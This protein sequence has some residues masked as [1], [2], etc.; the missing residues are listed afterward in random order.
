MPCRGDEWADEKDRGDV[1]WDSRTCGALCRGTLDVPGHSDAASCVILDSAEERDSCERQTSGSADTLWVRVWHVGVSDGSL[2]RTESERCDDGVWE[3]CATSSTYSA[4]ICPGAPHSPVLGARS[5]MEG[6]LDV[7]A[8]FST[9]ESYL[10][11]MVDE[12]AASSVRMLA[13]R[14]RN[15]S[16]LSLIHI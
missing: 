2:F 8:A 1:S 5:V 16:V 6:E 15:A 12:G 10:R 4:R 3:A 14:V 13:R 9:Y 7:S 11:H